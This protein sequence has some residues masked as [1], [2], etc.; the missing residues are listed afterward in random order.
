MGGGVRQLL[1]PELNEL[2]GEGSSQE[3]AGA[4]HVGPGGQVGIRLHS[5]A[6]EAF[7]KI[8]GGVAHTNGHL[9]E[10]WSGQ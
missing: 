10:V 9:E 5:S 4:D 8:H 6:M 3:W 2:V 7:R 1:G